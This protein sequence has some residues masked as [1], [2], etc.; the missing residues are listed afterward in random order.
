MENA[1]ELE[2]KITLNSSEYEKGLNDASTKTASF[3]SKLSGGLATAAKVG[4]AAVAAIGTAAV[5]AGAGLVKSAK[6][7]AAAGDQIDKL[8]QKIGISKKAYQEWDYVLSQNGTDISIL[9]GGMKTLSSAITDAASGTD[10]AVQKFTNLGLSVEELQGLSQEDLFS[11]VITRLQEMPESAERASMAVDLLG[12]SATELAPLINSGADATEALKQQAHDLGMVMSD[13]A[14]KASADFTDALDNLQRAFAGAKNIASAEFLPALADITN[15]F[16]NLLAGN[17]G[18]SEQIKS[19]MSTLVNSIS[20]KLPEVTSTITELASTILEVAPDILSSLASGILQSLPQLTDTAIAIIG[21]LGTSLIETAPQLADSAAQILSSLSN[22]LIT[23]LPSMIPAALELIF[24]F[25]NYILENTDSIISTGIDL[26]MALSDGLI[27]SI[28]TLTERLPVIVDG[29]SNALVTNAPKLADAAGQLIAALV[30]AFIANGPQLSL[31]MLKIIGAMIS[32]TWSL[33]IKFIQVGLDF[34]KNLAVGIVNG[35]KQAISS[36][37]K[38]TGGLITAVTTKVSDMASAGLDLVKGIWSG[39]SGGYTWITGKI[40]GWVGDVISF[41]KSK[42]GIHSPSTVMR[43]EVGKYLAQGLYV[44]F[45]QEDVFSKING[46]ISGGISDLNMTAKVSATSGSTG[47]N[48]LTINYDALGEAV[49]K[50]LERSN[51]TVSIGEREFG[52]I[53]RSVSYA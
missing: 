3:G 39:I 30:E 21:G 52:R 13:E 7:T 34:I 38:L 45:E 24:E 36:V 18:A 51:L 28:P 40:S 5:A 25:G 48:S 31:A 2:A 9:Q 20:D 29:I 22:S 14:V 10:S 41:I 4:T 1:F 12:R 42:F 19:G 6:E 43:D 27:A 32:T 26:I 47:S 35:T 37:D 49:A 15:G 53:V 44:G 11:T 17:E 23:N 33:R 8:S 16:A 50:A 46:E